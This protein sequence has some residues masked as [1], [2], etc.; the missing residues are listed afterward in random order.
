MAGSSPYEAVQNFV[1]PLQRAIGCVAQAKFTVSS[2]GKN[3]VYDL[4]SLTLNAGAPAKLKGESPLLLEVRMQYRIIEADGQRGPYKVKTAAYDYVLETE[5]G[6][7]V[8]A[9]HWHP[10]GA[11]GM[12]APH[13]HLGAAVL[14]KEGVL[15]HKD[16]MPTGRVPFEQVVRF[17]ISDLG[18]EPKCDDWA[19]V[20][21][22]IETVF[23]QWR[24]W[25]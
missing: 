17:A 8:V 19:E 20:L 22:D 16:H 12:K 2:G 5:D 1:R 10:D 24:T 9:Y 14:A 7:I 3:E 4:H 11:S 6:G 21:E 25:G 15:T 13:A 23:R 18:A